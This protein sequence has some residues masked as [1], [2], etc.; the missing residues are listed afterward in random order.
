MSSSWASA[1]SW[2]QEAGV[3]TI[4]GE[5]PRDWLN[6]Q[7]AARATPMVAPAPAAAVFP[8]TLEAFQA[9]LTGSEAAPLGPL[10]AKR[11]GPSGPAGAELMVMIDMPSAEDVA[12]GALLTGESGA[13]FD[14]MMAAIDRSREDLY[15]ASLAPFR[16]TLG[17]LDDSRAAAFAPVARHHVGL[18]RPKALLLLGDACTKALLETGVP[19]ARGRS[20][21][22]ATP[23][24][25]VSTF[26]TLRL[27]TLN[28]DPA[29]KKHAW[30][31][32]QLL[33]ESLKP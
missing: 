3:D 28:R 21:Q 14:R 17:N 32:L 29:M 6:P 25:P 1:L 9:W 22:L 8:D 7:P 20:H 30:Q 13:L 18:V 5:Q 10:A 19:A 26:A 2:W 15:L 24:G 11:V 27:D 33:R 12:A 4:V 16:G 23:S 31:D